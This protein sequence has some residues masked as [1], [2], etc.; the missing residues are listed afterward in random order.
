MP[1][2]ANATLEGAPAN[3]LANAG[4]AVSTATIQ[5]A[6]RS[7][8]A[9]N[10][11]YSSLPSGLRFKAPRWLIWS[12][13]CQS[14]GPFRLIAASALLLTVSNNALAAI[15]RNGPTLW[16]GTP[17]MSQRGALN[18]SPDGKLLYVPFGA[19]NDRGAGWMVAVDTAAPAFASA[20]AGAPSSVA[21]ANGGMWASGGPAVDDQGR[22]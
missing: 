14:V 11:T 13:P 2:F 18:L 19:Y 8:Y 5:P 21:F 17:E 9:P 4:A 6:P 22:L 20:F 10:G 12:V 7:L 1:P 16:Q 15:N 3:A